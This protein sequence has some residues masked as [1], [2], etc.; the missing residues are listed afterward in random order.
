[1]KS[2]IDK[3]L[4]ICD[5]LFLNIQKNYYNKQDV[6]RLIGDYADKIIDVICW[7]KS[8]PMP[9]SG[10]NVTNSWEFI[11]IMS[12]TKKSIRTKKTYTKNH[13][14]TSVYSENPYK[15]IHR[16]VMKPEVV[17]WFLDRFTNEGDTVLDCFMGVGTTGVSCLSQN[18]NFIGI[19]IDK[20]YFDI[21]EDRL[22]ETANKER[23][24]CY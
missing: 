4:E 6:F 24:I 14:E 17:D 8:N 13:I 16:A 12:K 22:N 18:R 19:E 5:Y 20:T 9:A 11:F 21:A 15:R 1:M 3:N 10:F 7:T 23:N 2:V